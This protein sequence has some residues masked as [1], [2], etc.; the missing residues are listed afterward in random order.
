M[1]ALIMS[2]E[3][4]IARFC[5]AW[6]I[7]ELR[8]FGSVTTD[9]F[10]PDSDIDLVVD[11]LPGTRPTLIQLAQMEEELEKI[12]GR[13]IDLLTRRAVETSRNYLRKEGILSSMERIYVA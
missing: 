2:R 5:R 8:A 12:F 11:F 3:K 10:R 9:R 7:R 1:H 13:R 4:E 6:N